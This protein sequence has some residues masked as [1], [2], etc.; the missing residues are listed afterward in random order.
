MP[1]ISMYSNVN[2]LKSKTCDEGFNQFFGKVKSEQETCAYG[3]H[4]KI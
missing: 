1:Y 4:I 2:N 3:L